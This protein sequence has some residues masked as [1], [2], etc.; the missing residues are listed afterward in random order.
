MVRVESRLV[1]PCLTRVNAIIARG[2][3]E[4]F[5]QELVYLPDQ[6][7]NQGFPCLLTAGSL[8]VLPSRGSLTCSSSFQLASLLLI[9]LC[10]YLIFLLAV[11]CPAA[12]QLHRPEM[13]PYQSPSAKGGILQAI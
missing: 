10:S 11:L 2:L 6:F 7:H 3:L 9:P 13:F 5:A 1:R 8:P 4:A 12:R